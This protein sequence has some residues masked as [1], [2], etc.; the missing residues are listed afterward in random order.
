MQT[1]KCSCVG[2]H[3]K[4]FRI[5]LSHTSL[6]NYYETNFQLM[7]HHKYSLTEIDTLIPWERDVYINMLIEHIKEET[8]RQKQNGQRINS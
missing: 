4:F 3:A 1:R 7:Q 2:G 8:E 6:I 5:S